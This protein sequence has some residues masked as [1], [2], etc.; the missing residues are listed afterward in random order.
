MVILRADYLFKGVC[1]KS[2]S[3]LKVRLSNRRSLL[4]VR[5]HD[6][7]EVLYSHHLPKRRIKQSYSTFLSFKILNYTTMEQP[8]SWPIQR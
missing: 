3:A 5:V 2:P 6:I 1:G 7:L 8:N 4:Y